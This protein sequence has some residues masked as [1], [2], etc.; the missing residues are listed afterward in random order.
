M[1]FKKGDSW[2]GNSKGR[3]KKPEIEALR[4]ALLKVE[5]EQGVSFIEHF[6]RK[7]YVNKEMAIALAKKILPD[8]IRA[9]ILAEVLM[10]PQIEKD[11]KPM[12][13]EVGD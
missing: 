3:P 10:M 7:A 12:E 9:D 5:A 1:T 6:V 4:D 8:Q 11:G 2:N 13:H